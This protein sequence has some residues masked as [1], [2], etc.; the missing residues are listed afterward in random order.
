MSIIDTK[1]SDIY[2]QKREEEENN[3]EEEEEGYEK[4]R[5]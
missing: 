1:E 3:D 2:Q 4:E 5:G